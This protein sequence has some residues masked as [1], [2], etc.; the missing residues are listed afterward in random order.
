MPTASATIDF[1]T[2]HVIGMI[3]QIGHGG[4]PHGLKKTG[5]STFAGKLAIRAKKCIATSCTIIG[6]HTSI[7]PVFSGKGALSA[8][9]SRYLK[10]FIR[11]YFFPFRIRYMK[12]R[13]VGSGIIRIT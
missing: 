7:I 13:G 2:L 1:Y 6:S 10:H 12:D 11:K 5:P 8:L 9:E 4:S 3:I